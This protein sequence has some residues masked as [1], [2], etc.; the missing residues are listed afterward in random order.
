MAKP[1]SDE[2]EPN[3]ATSAQDLDMPEKETDPAGE[4]LEAADHDGIEDAEVVDGSDPVTESR[5]EAEAEAESPAPMP[6]DEKVEEKPA[7]APAAAAPP[8]RRGLSVL[9]GGVLAAAIGAGA[10]VFALPNMPAD[11]R[12][13]ILPAGGGASELQAALD[14][15]AAK[16][17]ALEAATAEP[18]AGADEVTALKAALAE[19]TAKVDALESGAAAAAADEVAG[20]KEELAA[21]K[22][23]MKKSPM[24]ATQQQLDAATAEAK[25]RI[26]EAEAQAAKMRAETEAATQRAVRQAAVARVAAAFDAGASLVGPVAEVEAAGLDAPE[27]LKAEVPTV[28][29]LQDAFPDAARKALAVARTTD[30]GDSLTDKLG[31]FLLAQTGARSLT[32]RE[33]NSPDA[34][35]SRAQAAVDAAQFETAV[36]ELAALPE[37]AQA[38]MQ[39]WKDMVARRTAAE[40][41]LSTLAQSVQ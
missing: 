7:P 2:T 30:S 34:I 24:Y 41:A 36:A 32:A 35:L 26:A 16:I 18:T 31:T 39:S 4:A 23:E 8:P 20:L 21:M 1:E 13:K 25:A 27:A 11:L 3:A 5:T 6:D 33:G 17:A 9:V 10:T 15:Q 12:D 19:M 14:A 29:A 38:Q 22:E 37:A 28:G 40:A